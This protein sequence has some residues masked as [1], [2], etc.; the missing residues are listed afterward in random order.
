M[1]KK[2]AVIAILVIAVLLAMRYYTVVKKVDP[3][4]YSI[5][6]KIATVEKQAFGAGYF[7]LTTLSALARECGTTVDSE[8]LRSIETKLNPL[9]G[10]KYIFTY[11]GESQQA[12]VYV[13]TVIPNAPGYETLDQFKKDFDFCAVGG[14][15][16]PHALSAGWL[17]F[18]SSCG[19][20]YRDESGRPVG[21]EEVEKALG[22]SLKLK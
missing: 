11:Q 18:V 12:N 16:Y 10:V 9:M 3:L 19:S 15:Y 14:D 21:C 13:V 20:G 8:H 22:D 1:F 17:M 7:N 2:I 4:M 6:S 5:D